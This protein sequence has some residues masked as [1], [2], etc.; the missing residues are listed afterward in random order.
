MRPPRIPNQSRARL[1]KAP[2]RQAASI[3]KSKKAKEIISATVAGKDLANEEV[4][5]VTVSQVL[6]RLNVA[7]I[8]EVNP[9]KGT[10]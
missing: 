9:K 1:K 7:G 6:Y 3:L 2:N 10:P 4:R 5:A 8:I